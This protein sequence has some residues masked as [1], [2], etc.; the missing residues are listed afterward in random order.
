MIDT[1]QVDSQYIQVVAEG[2]EMVNNRM[3]DTEFFTGA[4][5]VDWDAL[6]AQIGATAGKTGT[7][8][9]CDNIAI[10]RGWCRFEDIAQRRILPTHAWYVG[11]APLDNPQIAVAVFIFNGGEGSQWAAP[12]ACHVMAAY[13]RAGQYAD[14]VRPASDD[15]EAIAAAE[16]A[17]LPSV[18]D[19]TVFNPTLPQTEAEIAAEDAL[20]EQIQPTPIPVAPGN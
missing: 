20:L 9:Y 8:E 1:L 13:F 16:A 15:P 17:Q 7:A 11:Y 19:S 2:M 5:Y 3:S 10:D 12:V 14:P 4:T 6:E 18:C